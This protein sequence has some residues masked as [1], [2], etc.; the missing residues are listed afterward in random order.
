MSIFG[1][2]T[3]TVHSISTVHEHR[4]PTD[5]SVKLLTEMEA[6]AEERL[7]KAFPIQFNSLNATVIGMHSNLMCNYNILIRYDINGSPQEFKAVIPWIHMMKGTNPM[8]LVDDIKAQFAAHLSETLL[9]DFS[10]KV[11]PVLGDLFKNI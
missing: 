10:P 8:T 3:V 9:S 7:L 6:K 4:A 11:A 2:D 5:A 1:P